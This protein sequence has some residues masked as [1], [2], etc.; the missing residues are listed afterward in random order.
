MMTDS[1]KNM[2]AGVERMRLVLSHIATFRA[3]DLPLRPGAKDRDRSWCLNKDSV[4]RDYSERED[5]QDVYAAAVEAEREAILARMSK[6]AGERLAKRAA[7]ARDDA[8]GV[9]GDVAKDLE[10]EA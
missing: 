3:T 7:A 9:L 1:K 4:L 5:L 8:M 2:L 10:A 6:I